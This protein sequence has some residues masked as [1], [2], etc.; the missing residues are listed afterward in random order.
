M[1]EETDFEG[2]RPSTSQGIIQEFDIDAAAKEIF[3]S[4]KSLRYLIGNPFRD[5]ETHKLR[6]TDRCYVNNEW[7]VSGYIV[8]RI[9]NSEDVVYS[10]ILHWLILFL[11]TVVMVNQIC[12]SRRIIS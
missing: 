3:E 8:R 4:D 10:Q 7:Y 12:L 6:R 5:H 1:S 11:P 2:E 9:N